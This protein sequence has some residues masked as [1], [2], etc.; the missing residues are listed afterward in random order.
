MNEKQLTLPQLPTGEL[1][2]TIGRLIFWLLTWIG[3]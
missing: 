3:D 2:I 1:E